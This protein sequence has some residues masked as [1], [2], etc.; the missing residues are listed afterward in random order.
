MIRVLGPQN[1]YVIGIGPRVVEERFTAK[2]FERLWQIYT[3]KESLLERILADMLHTLFNLEISEGER[4][5][6]S[7]KCRVSDL[8]HCSGYRQLCEVMQMERL[9][10]YLGYRC[11]DLER[12]KPCPCKRHLTDLSYRIRNLNLTQTDVH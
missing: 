4:L 11:R 5:I 7:F 3:C 6:G 12:L 10:S 8:L 9:L 1:Y 2:S